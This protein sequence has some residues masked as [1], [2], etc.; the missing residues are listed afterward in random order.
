MVASPPR[1]EAAGESAGPPEVRRRR[2]RR[3]LPEVNEARIP[4]VAGGGIALAVLA[5]SQ[6]WIHG[7]L[8]LDGV[9]AAML[10]REA[11]G[12]WFVNGH[13]PYWLSD[14]WTGTPLFGLAPSLPTLDVL[15]LASVF[16]AE[17][18]V[19]IAI[20][21]A[22]IVGGWGAFVL[23]TALWGRRCL[24]AVVA[25]LIY[26]LHPLFITH[27]ALFGHEPAV[28]V[29]AATPWLAWSFRKALREDRTGY[30]ALAG[31]IAAFAVL[32]QAE[33]AYALVLMC[34]C[35]L[36][37]ELS[38]ARRDRGGTGVAPV[39]RRAA[40][41][42]AIALGL[43]AFW[44]LPFITMSKS[45]VLTPPASVKAELTI[46]SGGTLGRHPEAWLTRSTG[47]HGAT[48]FEAILASFTK[49]TGPAKGAFYL[50][51]VCVLLTVVTILVL[52]R[53]DGDGHLTAIVFASAVGV[54]LSAGGVSLAGSQLVSDRRIVPLVVIGVVG[55]FL[56]HGFLRHLRLR[57]QLVAGA[58]SLAFLVAMPYL[59]PFLTLQRLVPFLSN[60]RFPRFYPLAALGLALGAAFPLLLV[61]RWAQARSRTLGPMLSVTVALAVVGAFLVDVAPYRSYYHLHPPDGTAAYAQAAETLKAAGGEFRVAPIGFGDPRPVSALL[62]SGQLLSVGWPHPLASKRAWRLTVEALASPGSYRDAALGLSGTA[63]LSADQLDPTGNVVEKVVLVRNPSVLPL[64]RAYDS[65]A[66]VG[67][68]DVAPELATALSSKHIGVVSGGPKAAQSLAPFSPGKVAPGACEPSP[69]GVSDN[70]RGDV[71]MA[72]AAHQ[73][74]GVYT[75]L[76]VVPI[77]N[78][79]GVFTAPLDELR[80]MKVWFDRPPS[81]AELALRPVAADGSLGPEAARAV[82]IGGGG[83][84]MTT[85]TFDPPLHD[86]AGK[87]FAFVLSCDRCPAGAEPRM[88]VTAAERGPGNLLV[89]GVLDRS[90]M[91]AFSLIYDGVASAEPSATRVSAVTNDSGTW[92]VKTSGAR[93]SVVVVAAAWFPGWE[94]RVDG[95]KAP[96]LIADGAFLGVAVPPGEHQLVLVYKK[97]IV[98]GVGLAITGATLIGV[99]LYLPSRRPRGWWRWWRWRDT[100]ATS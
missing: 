4:V 83:D 16:G 44:L 91:A 47:L 67:D 53:H 18:A 78:V 17:T 29:M 39:F 100:G 97:P 19:R 72:C 66:V 3:R 60:V 24:A 85:Y 35:L 84:D 94:A 27:G 62:E 79:G 82:G 37:V 64:V 21:A 71:A 2:A 68:D 46:G 61:Q 40:A 30:V 25:G 88:V 87:R 57:R 28:W 96:V 69:A 45:F 56:V 58:A 12:H 36:A 54:W 49:L 80:G 34:A 8:T 51:W 89:N 90:Q 81:G 13:V 92:R 76:K 48:S 43:I 11:L 22:Q 63:Y 15:P 77:G 98:A 9:G 42:A 59:T 70:L 41:S 50:S 95:K 65:V 99:L 52:P 38:R 32:H 74:L 1:T 33:H 5:F 73:W 14:M 31:G 7:R 75:G 20:V 86:A 26:A 6:A 23:A 93:A 55:G 10:V